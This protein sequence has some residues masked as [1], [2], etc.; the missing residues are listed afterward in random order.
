[1]KRLTIRLD[2]YNFERLYLLAKN[3][4]VSVNK[5]VN[6]LLDDY[7]TKPKELDYIQNMK[8]SIDE[9][10]KMITS[11]AKKQS[12]H[13]KISSQHFANHGYLSNAAVD[14]DK[15]LNELLDRKK[16]YYD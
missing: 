5:M 10:E 16:K 3:N 6:E 15:C 8:L 2:D 4:N 12:L 11:I 1:M 7:F 9:L 13:F 14:E